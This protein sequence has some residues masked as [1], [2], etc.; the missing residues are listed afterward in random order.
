[1]ASRSEYLT[2]SLLGEF[3]LERIGPDFVHNRKIPGVSLPWRPD[4]LS[5]SLKLIVEFD[6]WRHYCKAETAAK[7][8]FKDADYA[9]HGYKLIRIPY[10]IQLDSRI[11]KLLFSEYTQDFSDFNTYPHGFIDPKVVYPG[12]FC[13]LGLIR[14][15][16]E[17]EKT[18]KIVEDDIK[19]SIMGAIDACGGLSL[20]IN[21]PSFDETPIRPEKK[22]K[23]FE[24]IDVNSA[25]VEPG[26]YWVCDPCYPKHPDKDWDE[27]GE[28]TNWFCDSCV[29]RTDSWEV[30]G[31]STK[32]GDGLYRGSNGFEY[33]VDAGMI[34]LTPSY[35]ARDRPF[36][37]TRLILGTKTKCWV[38]T[39][40]VMHFGNLTIN[41][42][43]CLYE[44]EV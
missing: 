27:I 15:T 42:G 17:L 34:G 40:G 2:E 14:Y 44:S 41:T 25:L 13:E 43:D 29:G 36:G 26:E 24:A 11:I 6:G 32:Y 28:Q 33:P 5:E 20:F 21:P 16:E 30:L 7:D 1:M 4:Y 3:L 35:Y 37:A 38:D 31:F 19:A 22:D 10:F 39:S 23:Y 9:E 12:D 18:F 8:I